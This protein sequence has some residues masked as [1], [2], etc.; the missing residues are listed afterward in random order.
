MGSNRSTGKKGEKLA[1]EWLRAQG[2][3]IRH[4]NWRTGK[5]EIDIIAVLNDIL[6]FVE[7][8]TSRQLQYGFPEQRV[9][10]KKMKSFIEAGSQYQSENPEWLKVQYDIISIQWLPGSSPTLFL[11]EDVYYYEL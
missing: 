10:R 9:H 5:K 4:C 8:K 2:Y 6:H 1:E 11:L 3:I 7:V